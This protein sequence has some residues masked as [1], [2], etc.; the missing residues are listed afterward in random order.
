[1]VTLVTRCHQKGVTHI[2]L[3]SK[4]RVLK[5]DSLS[6]YCDISALDCGKRKLLM[7]A[8]QELKK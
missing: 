8:Y 6:H 5:Y 7:R 3:F 2:N 1:M 4:K